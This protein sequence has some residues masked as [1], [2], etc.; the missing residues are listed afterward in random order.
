M[1]VNNKIFH[2]KKYHFLLICFFLTARIALFSQTSSEAMAKN[3][4]A[5]SVEVHGGKAYN[6]FD[7]SFDFRQFHFRVRQSRKSYF[8]QR[9]FKDTLGN[10][11]ADY[12]ENGA[13]HRTVNGKKVELSE[14]EVVRYREATNSVPYFILLPYKLLDKA[15]NPV[16]IG[17]TTIEGE[18]YHKIKVTFDQE[19]GGM[20]YED[21][22]CYWF[23]KKTNTLDYLSYSN[24]GPRFRKVIKREKVG[25]LIMQDYHNYQILDKEIPVTEYDKAY[26]EGKFKLLSTIEQKNY[27]IN[28]K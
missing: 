26:L 23:N 24:G 6:A 25:D 2:M 9:S 17:E 16:Y 12:L 4:I 20:D 15:V 1:I 7:I 5:K 19:G 10:E 18:T 11:I 8:Y 28:K 14:K 21:Q 27:R 13:F 3:I 22:F